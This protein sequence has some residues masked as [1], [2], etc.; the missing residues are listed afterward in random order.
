[1]GHIITLILDLL[2]HWTVSSWFS[3]HDCTQQREKCG[4][5]KWFA[6]VL[7]TEMSGCL[8]LQQFVLPCVNFICRPSGYVQY[9]ELERPL[10][11][12]SC[13]CVCSTV[14]GF[15][16]A[17]MGFCIKYTVCNMTSA[18]VVQLLLQH[19]AWLVCWVSLV[20][21]AAAVWR[22]GRLLER[23]AYVG[24]TGQAVQESYQN[25]PLIR[26]DTNRNYTQ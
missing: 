10:V 16:H 20:K 8:S 17:C 3:W 18:N 23:K 2:T 13:A 5:C 4:L 14:S 22:S 25:E 9:S 19:V 7:S 12:L 24:L 15:V 21:R 6:L 26:L 11:M 1:M